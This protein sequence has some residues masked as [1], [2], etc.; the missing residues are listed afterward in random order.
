MKKPRF[1]FPKF[2]RF[3][4]SCYKPYFF[5]VLLHAVTNSGLTVY[6]AYVLSILIRYLEKGIYREALLAGLFIVAANLIFSFLN[7]LNLR[8]ME[9]TKL[10]MQESI[11]RKVTTKLMQLPYQYLEDPYYLDL[12]ERAKF[13]IENQDTINRFLTGVADGL[14]I[15]MTLIGLLTIILLF[16]WLLLGIL[17][18]AVIL[19]FLILALSLKT[20]FTIFRDLLPINRKFGYYMSTINDERRGKDYRLYSVGKLMAEEFG[21]YGEQTMHHFKK[22]SGKLTIFQS[23]D[24]IVKYLEMAFVY[25]FVAYRTISEKLSVSSFSL[26]ISTSLSFSASF[27]KL[28]EAGLN[29]GQAI[30]YLGPFIELIELKEAEEEGDI[31]LDE[32]R[33]IEF[34]NV[35]F[36]YPKSEQ[37]ILDNIFFKIN[38]GEKISIVG[39]NG[40]G[41]TTLIKLL[42]RLYKPNSG[43]ILVNGISIFDYDYDSYLSQISAVFQD[44][45][46]FSYSLKENI[47]NA[48][49][50]EEEAYRVACQVGLKEK[51]DSLPDGINSLYSKIYDEEGIELSG[52]E[53]Q[54]VAIARA[55]YKD[56]SLV[57]LDEPTS[58]LD[59]LAEAEIYQHFNEL[60]KEKTAIYI[61]H[62]MSSSV[63]CDRIIVIESG[64][65]ADID[66]HAGLMKK[67]DSLYYQLFMT[68]A[69]NYQE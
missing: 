14:Q 39:L 42:C 16:D 66:T 20:Q 36:S 46:L 44:Y 58:A 37:L 45:K 61:S 62:R 41:K 27:N 32:I 38:K 68:Q 65:I 52:G 59:P 69:Q 43:E 17:I 28:I 25:C 54:K 5:A 26:Y 50:D 1:V 30:S 22:L 2:L 63:F 34:R 12:K 67:K 4:F 47:L 56:S 24:R 11:N 10:K 18:V 60:V 64:K 13:A 6:N 33:E 57:I 15:I 23:L 51:I 3:A 35:S 19:N 7:K 29:L 53:A 9:T 21:N 48:D 55:L 40:A 8:I 49:G 31:I